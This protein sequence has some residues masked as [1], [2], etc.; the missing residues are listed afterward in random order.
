MGVALGND[1]TFDKI[2]DYH[3]VAIGGSGGKHEARG[4]G[5]WHN[6]SFEAQKNIDKKFILELPGDLDLKKFETGLPEIYQ[7]F[8]SDLNNM[9]NNA[10]L[11]EKSF[12]KS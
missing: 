11:R 3:M 9:K 2:D 12:E 10:F 5:Y 7:S 6:L 4:G 8:V 1:E